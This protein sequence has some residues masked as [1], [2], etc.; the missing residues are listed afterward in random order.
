M[1]YMSRNTDPALRRRTLPAA[2]LALAASTLISACTPSEGSPDTTPGPTATAPSKQHPTKTASKSAKKS[3]R[4]VLTKALMDKPLSPRGGDYN[5]A[6]SVALDATNTYDLEN[7]RFVLAELQ[8]ISDPTIRNQASVSVQEG[9][10]AFAALDASNAYDFDSSNEA[11]NVLKLVTDP[12]IRAKATQAVNE[13]IAAEAVLDATEEEYSDANK[14]A[15]LVTDPTLQ[16]K[17]SQAISKEKSGDDDAATTVWD[18]LNT[19]ATT[20]WDKLDTAATE[21]WYQLN[22]HS[23]Q[24]WTEYEQAPD[25]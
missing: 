1:L 8:K 19:K 2:V 23:D 12:A 13:G 4:A 18:S 20:D 17:I 6:S 22:L 16:S 14:L 5:I 9:I 3:K 10:G 25:K 24:Y 7:S 21:D 15:Q 11:I